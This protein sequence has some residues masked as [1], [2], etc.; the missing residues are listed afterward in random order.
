M[1]FRG[2]L[3]VFF[4]IIVVIPMIAVALVLFSLT[5][6][7]EHG[8]VDARL[9]GGLRTTLVA[10]TRRAATRGPLGRRVAASDD[11]LVAGAPS[12]RRRRGRS[13]PARARRSRSADRGARVLPRPSGD[14]GRHAPGRP[15]GV[16]AAT[17]EPTTA[18]GERLGTLAASVTSGGRARAPE[19]AASRASTCACCA[20]TACSPRRSP[21]RASPRRSRATST[22]AARSTAPASQ[23]VREPAGP[24]DAAST[25]SRTRPRWRTRSTRAAC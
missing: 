2:R 10:S 20:A 12:G 23:E 1:S 6:D 4:T 17:V 11:A 21:A 7:S 15:D 5:E 18:D 19:R 3:L 16:A 14:A 9:A 22:S 8:K 24:A 25:C 13:A